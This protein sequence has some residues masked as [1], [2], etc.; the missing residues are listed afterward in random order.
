V[1]PPGT[2][3]ILA[4]AGYTKKKVREYVAAHAPRPAPPPARSADPKAPPRPAFGPNPDHW[5]VIV[6]GGPGGMWIPSGAWIQWQEWVVEK[7]ELPKN[8][9]KVVAKYKNVVPVYAKY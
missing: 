9:S 6:S 2:A 1:I 8:W 3:K 5:A 4:E 7:V